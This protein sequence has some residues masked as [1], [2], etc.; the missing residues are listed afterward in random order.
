LI[1]S[2]LADGILLLLFEAICVLFLSLIFYK[3]LICDP[4]NDR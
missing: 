2:T 4:S 3:L 1:F